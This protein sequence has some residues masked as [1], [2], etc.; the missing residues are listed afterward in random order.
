MRKKTHSKES[1]SKSQCEK[2]AVVETRDPRHEQIQKRRNQRSKTEIHT[3][4]KSL[5]MTSLIFTA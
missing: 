4:V 1:H 5:L 2:Q 3:I